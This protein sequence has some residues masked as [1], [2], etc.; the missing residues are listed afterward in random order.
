MLVMILE[1]GPVSLRGELSRWLVQPATGVFLGNP[2]RRVRDELWTK[3]CRKIKSGNVIQ[4][5]TARNEQG[6]EFRQ[7]G[8][9]KRSITDFEGLALVTTFKPPK[10]QKGSKTPPPTEV[11]PMT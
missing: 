2:S 4:I 3:A 7:H 5:W 8:N 11:P 10:K 6:Y 1:K 9:S